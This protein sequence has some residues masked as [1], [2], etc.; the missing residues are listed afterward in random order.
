MTTSPTRGDLVATMRA[1]LAEGPFEHP[2]EATRIPDGP[3]R[4]RGLAGTGK[5]WVLAHRAAHIL[6]TKPDWKIAFVYFTRSVR[7]QVDGL[8]RRFFRELAGLPLASDNLAVLS[9]WEFRNNCARACGLPTARADDTRREMAARSGRTDYITPGEVFAYDCGRLDPAVPQRGP[10]QRYDAILI[11]EGQDLPF[12][13]YR[14]A[15]KCLREPRRLYW[16]YDEAQGVDS[17]VIPRPAQVFDPRFGMPPVRVESRVFTRCYRTHRRN[18]I[19]AHAFSMGL[20]RAGGPV[21]GLTRRREW[22]KLG[23]I[24]RAGADFRRIGNPVVISRAP[25][26]DYHPADCDNTLASLAEPFLI[27]VAARTRTPRSGRSQRPWPT[28]CGPTTCGPRTSSSPPSR[29]TAEMSRTSGAS[30]TSSARGTGSSPISPAATLPPAA[31]TRRT[32]S[33]SR[34]G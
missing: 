7:Q 20:R 25:A 18:L 6:T 28:M 17:L 30:R 21:Q 2:A 32:P 12:P 8:V 34:A 15:Y 27:V 23:H 29:G 4:L 31:A 1:P 14:L 19:A 5:T 9:A 33:R 13:F 3:Q 22:E 24:V 26:T 16:A 11:D 10:L